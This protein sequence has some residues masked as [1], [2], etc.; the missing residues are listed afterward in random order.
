MMNT[1]YRRITLG[2]VVPFL[3]AAQAMAAG[4]RGTT[5]DAAT[6]IIIYSFTTPP[7]PGAAVRLRMDATG[8][9]GTCPY[10]PTTLL[11][12]NTNSGWLLTPPPSPANLL[13]MRMHWDGA[14][15]LGQT[16][17][18]AVLI[19]A[20]LPSPTPYQSFAYN[21]WRNGADAVISSFGLGWK[22]SSPPILYN[23]NVLPDGGPNAQTMVVRNLQ[24]AESSEQ[25]DPKKFDP[26]DP[27]VAAIFA[28]STD[29]VRVGPINVAPG[30]E[31][32]PVPAPTIPGTGRTILAR[33]TVDIS[34]GGAAS[35]V[36]AFENPAIV[37]MAPPFALAV[38][39]LL[40]FGMGVF[41]FRKS[42]VRGLA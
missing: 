21:T 36:V 35:F 26:T 4:P 1:K 42:G 32:A 13:W 40:L 14:G 11:G 17:T 6:P 37:P 28:A 16:F 25:I 5:V 29:P 31:L 9:S 2:V 27:R 18:G 8:K 23:H 24:F 19:P 20:C 3:A 7:T 22:I 34:G 33:G 12:A 38:M 15:K 39:G 30:A 41:Y 10:G